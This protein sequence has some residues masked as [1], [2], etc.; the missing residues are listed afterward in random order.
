VHCKMLFID[1]HEQTG[2]ATSREWRPEGA[3]TTD[4][5]LFSLE[6]SREIFD[7]FVE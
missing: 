1:T 5:E 2:R 7:I 4:E 6:V 3:S